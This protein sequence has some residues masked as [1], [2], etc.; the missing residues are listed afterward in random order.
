MTGIHY[1]YKWMVLVIEHDFLDDSVFFI[2]YAFNKTDP[3]N[4]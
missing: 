4:N 3:N 2:S 1:H